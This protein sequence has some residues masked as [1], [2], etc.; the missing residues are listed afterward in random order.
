M[1]KII[2]FPRK[3]KITD[4]EKTILWVIKIFEKL[5]KLDQ[6]KEC[7]LHI[8]EEGLKDI[9]GFE[10]KIEDIINAIE[11]LKREGAIIP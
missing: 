6:V 1:A 2:N 8:T 3:T 9:E 5:A 4:Q 11:Y 10:P 7:N